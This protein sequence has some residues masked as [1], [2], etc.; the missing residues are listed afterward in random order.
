MSYKYSIKE[1][2]KKQQRLCSILRDPRFRAQFRMLGDYRRFWEGF[3]N[4]LSQNIWII[5]RL[6]DEYKKDELKNL[7]YRIEELEYE[8]DLLQRATCGYRNGK[9]LRDVE[10]MK[11]REMGKNLT[12]ISTEVGISRQGVKK[13]LMRLGG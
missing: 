9:A 6:F 13:A 2:S 4:Y 8:Y 1:K 7:H 12:E 3:T 10:I 5:D 11:L